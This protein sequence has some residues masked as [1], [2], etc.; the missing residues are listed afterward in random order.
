[1]ARQVRRRP[2]TIKEVASRAGVA[3]SSVS[4]VLNEHPDVSATMRKRVLEAV[5][6][7][8]YEPDLLASG[9]RRGA[10]RTVGFVVP[11]IV[12]PLFADILKGAERRLRR[13]GYSVLLAHSEGDERRD[14]E[15]ARLFRRRRVDGLILSLTDETRPETLAELCG[16]DVPVVLLD[17]EVDADL[18]FAAVLS[19]HRTGIRLATEHLLDLGHR[20]ITLVTGNELTRPSRE[21]AAGFAEGFM[22]RG[23][24][25]GLRSVRYGSFSSEFGSQAVDDLL[26]DGRMPTAIIAGGNLIFVGIVRALRRH[27][28]RVGRDVALI[29]CDDT[30]LAELH[31]PPV[32]VV[33]R[34]THAM[35]SI[36]ADLLLGLMDENG[37]PLTRTAPT[38]LLVRGSTFPVEGQG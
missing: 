7:L 19:D 34:D 2:P 10:T 18:G 33:F 22:Q 11:D 26:R 35:G 5:G 17:R 13:S 29:S 24:T 32:T 30:A 31:E 21:R 27:G 14:V 37:Q 20:D 28:V 9:L 23:L 4:R 3:L 15:S 25:P 8:G 38:E 36:A 1:M 6:E 16:L 12:N